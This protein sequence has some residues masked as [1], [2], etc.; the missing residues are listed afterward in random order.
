MEKT[1]GAHGNRDE[2]YY[3]HKFSARMVYG[4]P[5]E[6]G[7]WFDSGHPVST[8]MPEAYSREED[9]YARCRELNA[10]ERE[11]AK[12]EEPYEYT[13]VVAYKSNHY[14][15]DVSTS[16]IAEAYPKERPHYE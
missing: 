14:S 2:I 16:P 12:K 9:A 3:V 11:R 13:S 5:E 7:W 10:Q 8:W 15:Y 6:G 1:L 4:G